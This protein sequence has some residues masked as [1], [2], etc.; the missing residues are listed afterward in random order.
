MA[1]LL[2]ISTR[3]RVDILLAVSYLATKV[4]GPSKKDMLKLNRIIGY[5]KAKNYVEV[6]INGDA[7]PNIE[8]YVDASYGTHMKRKSHTGIFV[9]LG[10]GPILVKSVKQKTVA[11]SSTEAELNGLSLSL[12]I[13]IG[14]GEFL[15]YQGID[16]K[17]IIVYQD[18]QS[19]IKMVNNGKAMSDHTRHI[20]IS[21]FFVKQYVDDGKIRLEYKPTEEM[22]ADAL[23]K[24]LQ[25]EVFRRMF[26]RLSLYNCEDEYTVE[27]KIHAVSIK[28]RVKWLESLESGQNNCELRVERF[29]RKVHC[30]KDIVEDNLES[31]SVSSAEG[32]EE[33]SFK[34]IKKK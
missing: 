22:V 11:K 7:L 18:N 13:I 34:K 20:E 26:N 4:S 30:W 12:S 31:N 25:G 16:V 1:R 17:E 2:Y 33:E 3:I 32:G 9:T 8:A 6:R 21:K 28:G 27:K 19:V 14:M 5:L 23:T 24:P 15:F 29:T 10:E